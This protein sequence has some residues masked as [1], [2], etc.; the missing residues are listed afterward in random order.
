MVQAIKATNSEGY[1]VDREELSKVCD[2]INSRIKQIRREIK[3]ESEYEGENVEE[4]MEGHDDSQAGEYPD[5]SKNGRAQALTDLS[6]DTTMGNL[7]TT[8]T[9]SLVEKKK[10]K[11]G[12]GK[13]AEMTEI[14]SGG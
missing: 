8:E 12:L 2:E 4:S 11:P 6:L 14:S 5:D 1:V 10:G 13:V 9:T 7:I 3:E